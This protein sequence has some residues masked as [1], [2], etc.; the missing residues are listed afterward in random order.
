MP[1]LLASVLV[2]P[3][4][5]PRDPSM[6]MRRVMFVLGDVCRRGR[7]WNQRWFLAAR[8]LVRPLEVRYCAGGLLRGCQD[9]PAAAVRKGNCAAVLVIRFP[10]PSLQSRVAASDTAVC[11][12][13]RDSNSKMS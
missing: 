1:A 2:M 7:C 3:A 13:P 10:S 9:V 12:P 8:R 4:P 11:L 6:R 5:T